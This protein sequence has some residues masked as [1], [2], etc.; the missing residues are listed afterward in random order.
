MTHKEETVR[1]K[2]RLNKCRRQ[3]EP[4]IFCGLKPKKSAKEI[5]ETAPTHAMG[6]GGFPHMVRFRNIL[7]NFPP[8][9]KRIVLQN[10]VQNLHT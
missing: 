10:G 4:T 2:T 7:S 8:I 6:E 5:N 3:K 1:R 9:F